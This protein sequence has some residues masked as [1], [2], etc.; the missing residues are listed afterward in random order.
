[1]QQ[2]ISLH[3]TMVS[4]HWVMVIVIPIP[5]GEMESRQK[6]LVPVIFKIQ[7]GNILSLK[8]DDN[9][10]VSG[11][12]LPFRTTDLIPWSME[13]VKGPM[14]VLLIFAQFLYFDLYFCRCRS[15]DNSSQ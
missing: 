5:K 12:F 9:L 14:S 8:T 3:N 2:V 6:S 13:Q 11:R 4:Q 1:M 15:T 10:P 7:P